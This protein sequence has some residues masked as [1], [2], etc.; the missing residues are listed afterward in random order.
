MSTEIELREAAE[1]AIN[2]MPCV[3]SY[4]AEVGVI[5]EHLRPL[6]QKRDAT[7]AELRKVLDCAHHELTTLHGLHATDDVYAYGEAQS[8]GCDSNGAWDCFRDTL[9]QIDC[10]KILDAIAAAWAAEETT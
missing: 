3:E 10:K 1:K 5:V 8:N 9:F 7:I 2:K 4:E 6:L